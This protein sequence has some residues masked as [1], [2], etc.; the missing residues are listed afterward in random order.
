MDN[1]PS[2]AQV[3]ASCEF[4][5]RGFRDAKT[6]A[7]QALE[8]GLCP[9]PP[10]M[11]G[12]KAPFPNKWKAYQESTP[13]PADIE[14]W[15]SAGLT[16]V[17]L[18]TGPIS[19]NLE[20]L[21]FDTREVWK[22]YKDAAGKAGL[23]DL[24]KKVGSG[25]AEQSPNGFHLLYR[26][27]DISGNT[28]LASQPLPDNKVKT[29]I[30]TR[31]EGGFIIVAPSTGVNPA[32]DYVLKA[33]GFDSI[34]R[35]SP[36]ERRQLHALAR[37]FDEAPRQ[38]YQPQQPASDSR[39][40]DEYIASTTWAEV[41]EPAG[42]LRVFEHNGTT[43]WRRPGKKQGVSATTGH[44]GSDL[45]YVFSTSTEF[46]SERGYNRFS[47]SALLN[48]GGDFKAAAAALCG[49]RPASEQ[50]SIDD[51]PVP[52]PLRRKLPPAEPFPVDALGDVLAPMARKISE[53]IQ[54]PEAIAGQSLAASATLAVQGHADVIIDGRVFP[55]SEN[56]VAVA[57]SGERKSA[58]DR[59]ALSPQ[60]KRQKDLRAGLDD[61]HATYEADH[62][63]WK[64]AREE[65]LSS[66]NNKGREAKKEALLKIGAEPQAPIDPVMMTEE[67]T[68]EGLVKSL[69]YG[70]PSMGIYSDEGGRFLGGHGMNSDN[71]LKTATGLSK[72]WDGD[73]ITRTRGGDGN[74]LLYGR[75]LS[76]HL[77]IQ[78]EISNALFGNQM[79][80]GQGLM[81]RCL[82]CYPTSNI[83]NRPYKETDLSGTPEMSRYFGRM[84][85][86]L[87]TPLPL[88][89]NSQNQLSP[90]QL[91]LDPA[92]KNTWIGFHDHIEKLCR[93]GEPLH[94]IKG[95]AAKAAEHAARLAGMLALVD[96]LHISTIQPRHIE[97]G[98]E[99]AQFYLGEALRL[100]NSAAE[101]PDLVL[102]EKLIIWAK[103]KSH[104]LISLP[105]VYQS[106]PNG[107]RDKATAKRIIKILADH[108]RL[109][110][111]EG[112]AEVA[113]K[114]R[115]EVWAVNA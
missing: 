32:G 30:E 31:G 12:S 79:L 81:S 80:I 101:N 44:N 24:L 115:R 29:L 55:V 73:P 114:Y 52:Q 59:A 43:H 45:L 5:S 50:S 104:P 83:G 86:L 84:M 6:A 2:E 21:D 58:T 13:S 74:M 48:H 15:Y 69:A 42:W 112:G 20:C 33:G 77:M 7:L 68:Y 19:G 16:G 1:S 100:F 111:F 41:L 105:L 109:I 62:A 64:K 49:R 53:I 46:D 36:N 56:F 27:D 91:P 95:F 54:S 106:G 28:K 35:I 65:A 75:R 110:P 22:Q 23:V 82:V 63:A 26:C 98:I 92:A 34:E 25:Y 103:D 78:P 18:V 10:R 9:I 107:I 113:G 11:D 99:L 89:E 17:G 4:I 93:D 38:D 8:A 51:R 70:W 76:V 39:P 67:P 90:R 60:H 96:D 47:A 61:D 66:R 14:S 108:D 3:R 94:P 85:S 88:A 37:T 40:G 97:A 71:Q 72:L 102:A 87:E 57:E